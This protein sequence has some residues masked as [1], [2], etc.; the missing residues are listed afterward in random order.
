MIADFQHPENSL[1]SK[2][3]CDLKTVIEE[4]TFLVLRYWHEAMGGSSPCD[5][6]R[7]QALRN[8]HSLMWHERQQWVGTASSQ[9]MRAAFDLR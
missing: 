5:H 6:E 2:G 1:L 8:G 7:Q 3:C 4:V 9:P